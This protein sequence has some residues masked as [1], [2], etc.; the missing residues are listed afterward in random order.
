[1]E[2]MKTNKELNKIEL[3]NMTGSPEIKTAKSLDDGTLLTIDA[4]VNF[5]DTNK[6]G[7]V[8]EILT[9]RTTD[10]DVYAVQSSTF[11]RSFDFINDV[12]TEGNGWTPN[13]F[14]IKKISG[15]SKGGRDFIDCVLVSI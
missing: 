15:I 1:M 14:T 5:T 6:D 9:I 2:I 8:V 3:Y 12:I 13:P 11:R 10:G 4:A 7:N